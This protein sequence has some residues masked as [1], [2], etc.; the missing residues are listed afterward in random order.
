MSIHRLCQ[1]QKLHIPISD[2]WEFLSNPKNLNEITPPELKFRILSGA[3]QPMFEGQIIVY[4]I[5]IAPMIWQRWV[6]EI[7]TVDPGRSFID[8]QRFGPYKF[9]H[10][11]HLLEA[12]GKHTIMHDEIH[13]GLG[14]GPFGEIAHAAYVRRKLRSIFACRRDVLEKRFNAG[15]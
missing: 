8:E 2:A 14:F 11:R 6:T 4:K 3:D 1:S 5:R 10:H 12:Q 9:W 7:K 13:Y 15:S